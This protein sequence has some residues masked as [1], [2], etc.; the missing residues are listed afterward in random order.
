MD[1]LHAE[2]HNQTENGEETIELVKVIDHLDDIMVALGYG[3]DY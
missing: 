3:E 2:L 1:I